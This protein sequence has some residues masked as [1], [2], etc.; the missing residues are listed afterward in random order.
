MTLHCT[1]PYR[2][3]L[4]RL[5][6]VFTAF[7]LLTSCMGLGACKL[8]LYKSSS[9]KKES[10]QFEELRAKIDKL[11]AKSS[12]PKAQMNSLQVG[13]RNVLQFGDAT[14][15]SLPPAK[16]VLNEDVGKVAVNAYAEK[17][18]GL[19]SYSVYQIKRKTSTFMW[20]I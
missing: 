19:W 9:A 10:S 16:E 20:R 7:A 15:F 12:Y 3:R 1:S 13:E 2:L 4:R 18:N 5:Q 6:V 11:A 14:F 8:A 17:L